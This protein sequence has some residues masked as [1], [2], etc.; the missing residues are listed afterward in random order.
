MADREEGPRGG[1]KLLAF[2][3]LGFWQAWWMVAMCTD[4]LLP[5]PSASPFPMGLSILLLALCCLGFLAVV[6]ARE[7]GI[8]RAL[9]FRGKAGITASLAVA[10]SLGMGLVAHTGLM[11]LF[12]GALFMG[13][14]AAFAL[15][16]ALLLIIWGSLWSTLASGYVGRLLC[17]SYTAAFAVFFVVKA[18]PIAAA[19]VVCALLPVASLVGYGFARRAP[20]RKPVA[21][22]GLAWRD[23]PVAKALVALFAA[24][25]VW[26]VSQRYLYVGTGDAFDLSFMFGAACLLAYT[27]FMFIA[28]P[29]DE[30]AALLRPIVPALVCGIAFMQMLPA[31]DVFLGEGVMIFGGYCLDM[32]VMLIASDLAFRMRSSVVRVFGLALFVARAGSLLGTCAGE[33]CK[34]A[35]A[36]S[37]AAAML[38]VVALVFVGMLLFSQTELNRFYQVPVRSAVGNLFSEKCAIIAETYGLTARERGVLDLLARGRS[39]PFISQELSIALGTAKNHISSI[40]RKIGVSDRQSLHNVIEREGADAPMN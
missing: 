36:S 22:T 23:L 10:G 5:D 4:A 14:A 24:N 31:E 32:F 1:G 34:A 15:G 7:A 3:G 9:G 37:S 2:I 33:W 6:L 25:F 12:G 26:G 19:V 16:N 8:G 38:C 29:T 20:R 21:R 40:Y 18:L 17:A 30:P 13:A 27:A 39:A 28:S 35:S 11:P